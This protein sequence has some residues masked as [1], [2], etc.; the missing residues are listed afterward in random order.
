[1]K[2]QLIL[3]LS[4][5][6][7]LANARTP[8]ER[9][10]NAPNMRHA[11]IGFQ[12]R[13]IA[14]NRVIAEYQ[15]QQS[16]TPAS[17]VKIVTT[18]A[19]LDILGADYRFTTRLQHDGNIGSDGTLN[20]N[21]II[22]GGGDPTLGSEFLGNADFAPAWINAV[23][24]AGIKNIEGK[25]IA[26]ASAFDD[27]VIPVGWT[28]RNMGNHY[29]PGIHGIAAFDNRYQIL[30]NSQRAGAQTQI[31]RTIPEMNYRFDNRVT[32][33]ANSQDSAYIYGAPFSGE[34][35]IRGT[36]P[37]NRTSF[38]VRGDIA[39]PPEFLANFFEK[40]LI[41]NGISV[42]NAERNFARNRT[43]I[44][45]QRSPTLAEIARV[46]NF[47]SN[48]LFAEHLFKYLSLQ[49]AAAANNNDAISVI[50]N[51][52]K[53]KGLDTS[54]IFLYDGSGLSPQ[55][56]IPADFLN[57]LLLLARNNSAFYLSLPLAGREGT[58][59]NFLK[60][61][62]LQGN[63]RL[64]SGSIDGVQAYAGYVQSGGKEYAV[65]IMVNRFTGSRAEVRRQIS[66]LLNEYF[67]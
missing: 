41:K 67:K 19:A 55:N 2:P 57:H 34:R 23:K 33:A 47:R 30:F 10:V 4:L 8:I 53:Q 14:T 18:A 1:M 7:L 9:F 32:A 15:S 39:N 38:V 49:N 29:A 12:I 56:A 64:K 58:V 40:E 26:D 16:L 43:L 59:A 45:T 65:T 25:I 13:E 36:I 35:I 37:Q 42:R 17:V 61:T 21:L 6:T 11:Q 24:Q 44:Y 48:N 52:W 27:E 31:V 50:L 66:E 5:F 22:R 54:G 51:H 63:A 62:P 46:T 28:W 20:G 60:N 3:F